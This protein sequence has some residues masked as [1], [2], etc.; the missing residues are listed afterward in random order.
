MKEKTSSRFGKFGCC[1]A[2]MALTSSMS[3][4]A[5]SIAYGEE[6]SN[7]PT[8][9]RS[10]DDVEATIDD[11]IEKEIDAAEPYSNISDTQIAENASAANAK[12]G[13][14]LLSAA[15]SSS[16]VSSFSGADRYETNAMQA[17]AGWDSSGKAIVVTG[18]RWPDA[19]SV[20]GLAGALDCPVI[21]VGSGLLSGYTEDALTSLGVES[22]IV[23]GDESSVDADVVGALGDLGIEVEAR[24]AGA[25]RFAT[26]MAVYEYGA[27]RGLWGGTAVVASGADGGFADFLSVSAAAFAAGLPVFLAADDGSI[28]DAQVAALRQGGFSDA[29]VLGGED[30]VSKRSEG[31]VHG[32]LGKKPSRIAGSDRYETSVGVAEWAVSRG[33]LSWDGAAFATGELPYDS[34][35]GGAL[36]G[37]EGSVLLLVD[38]GCQGC[39]LDALSS[40]GGASSIKFFGGEPS[41][42]VQVRSEI[43][44]KLGIADIAL[45]S[46]DVALE[47]VAS[48]EAERSSYTVDEILEILDPENFTYGDVPYYQFAKIGNYTGLISADQ[49]NAY[50][51]SC[52]PYSEERYGARSAMRGTGEYFVAAAKAY[53]INEVYLVAHAAIES[54]WGCSTLSQGVVEGYSGYYN[55]FGIGAYD[56]DPNNGGAA[57]AKEE[58]W[59]SVEKA[60]MGAA[61]WISGNY[62]HPTVSSAEISGAQ[63]TLYKMKWDIARIEQGED[64]WH[65]YATSVTW[66]TDGET[67]G[68]AGV[69][70]SFYRFHD[71]AITA[72]GLQFEVPV[73][74]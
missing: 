59:D 39:A 16:P 31:I 50:I 18:E 73:F 57:L 32:A 60:I 19:L 11:S 1:V 72:T 25:D 64:P 42:S 71:I 13:I 10:V 29:I 67:G 12:E 68:I 33:Y 44:T 36:Q 7:G 69:M 27:E 14:A 37:R 38:E 26:Q 35:G 20:S 46:Y 74:K 52:A 54:A 48:I 61:K 70:A 4:A 66:A 65:Q 30:R 28:S 51:D 24:L 47:D 45:R 6:P 23:V 49:I 3:L 56:L 8:G 22:V 63:D 58:G 40:N 15:R 21:L 34:L 53:D 5:P 2:A 62:I 43:M 55:F 17:K 41:I 9:V